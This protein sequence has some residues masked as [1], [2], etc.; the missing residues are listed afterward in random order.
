M[1]YKLTITTEAREDVKIV[2]KYYNSQLTGLGAKFKND[3]KKQFEL[4][5]RNP[6]VKSVRYDEVRFAILDN[7]P[8]SIHYTLN[9]NEII[10]YAIL[11]DFRNPS[12]YW[13]YDDK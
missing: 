9:G 10:V 13:V 1:E 5:K 6:Y 3:V 2:V 7:F 4:I 12:E 8:Y 11:S